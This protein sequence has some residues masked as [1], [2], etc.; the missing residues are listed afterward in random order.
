[1]QNGRKIF[2][3]HA[4]HRRLVSRIYKELSWSSQSTNGPV[5]LTE[6]EIQSGSK[7]RVMGSIR[8]LD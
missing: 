8:S 5:K 7:R 3:N 6:D 2:P 1:M 4:S